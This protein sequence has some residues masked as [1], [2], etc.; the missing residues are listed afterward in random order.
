MGP[1]YK[2]AGPELVFCHMLFCHGLNKHKD[3]INYAQRAAL[4]KRLRQIDDYLD[5]REF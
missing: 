1:Y 4:Y 5:S 2:T 3:E